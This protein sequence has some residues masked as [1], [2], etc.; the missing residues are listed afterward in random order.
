D[1]KTNTGSEVRLFVVTRTE[2]PYTDTNGGT[3]TTYRPVL[4]VSGLNTGYYEAGQ[5]YKT[6]TYDENHTS[7]KLHSTEEFTDKQGRV[8]LKR[9]YGPS[10]VDMDGSISTNEQAVTHD[11]YYVYDDYGNLTYVLPPKLNGTTASLSTINSNLDA[12]GFKYTYDG[13]NRLV[14]KQVPG[15][16]VEYVVYNKLDQPIL[17]QDANLR[18]NDQWLFTKYDAFGRVAYTGKATDNRE[19]I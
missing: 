7:G 15:K 13:R 18:I 19:R 11:T 8:V 16:V 5:L 10:D 12:L 2:E 9:T 1:Y 14:E 6:I 17:T 4:S 3:T